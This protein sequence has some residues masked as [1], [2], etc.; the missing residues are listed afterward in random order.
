MFG[1]KFFY[2][3]QL[4]TILICANGFLV[5]PMQII[6]IGLL[7]CYGRRQKMAEIEIPARSLTSKSFVRKAADDKPSFPYR[8]LAN[9]GKG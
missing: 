1:E 8:G 3:N 7:K 9:S 5:L 4:V 2:N 6:A